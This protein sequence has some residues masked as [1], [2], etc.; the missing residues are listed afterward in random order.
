MTEPRF[1][2][3]ANWDRFLR[4]LTPERILLAEQSLRDWLGP[5]QGCS[6]LDIGSGSGLFSLAARNLG[7]MVHSFDYD[8]TSVA[9]T[10]ELRYRF[11]HDDPEW[12]VERGSALDADYVRSIGTF[13][14]VYSWGVLHHT[15]QMWRALDLAT[16][17]MKPDGRL[18]IALYNRL[19]PFK[20]RMVALEKRLY[21]QAPSVLRF[22]AAGLY[23]AS[24]ALP[25]MASALSR[26][27]HPL[28]YF[29]GYA[30]ASRGMSWWTDVTDWLGGYPYEA[31]SPAAIKRWAADRT[32]A[33]A[34][35]RLTSGHGCNEFLL[36]YL[37]RTDAPN[38]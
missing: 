35:N 7:A 3:G 2:F 27:R 9:C 14:V 29:R 28:A 34:R 25:E 30:Q 19:S 32:L 1:A 31:A 6:F 13:D 21:N 36:T 17:P 12:T 26:R 33:V 24:V 18:Y 10:A 38:G 22:V 11:H 16:I 20:H 23:T 37:R 8:P 15:G 5:I 4:R